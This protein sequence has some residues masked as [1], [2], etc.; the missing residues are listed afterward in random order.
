M[1]LQ[2][3]TLAEALVFYFWL[4]CAYHAIEFITQRSNMIARN[5]YQALLKFSLGW[6]VAY[7]LV[8]PAAVIPYAIYTVLRG[9][10]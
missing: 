5:Q 8:A 10:K 6:R 4:L 1:T 3:P 2:L 9:A 7:L